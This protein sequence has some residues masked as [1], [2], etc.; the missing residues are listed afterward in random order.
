M[1]IH[2]YYYYRKGSI[3]KKISCCESQKVWHQDE[4]IDS[5]SSVVK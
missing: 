4:P 3:E 5:K 1:S 2:Y